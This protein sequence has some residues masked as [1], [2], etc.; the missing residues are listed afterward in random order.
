MS[1]AVVPQP[2]GAALLE[3]AVGYARAALASVRGTDP[4]AAT[5]CQQWDLRRLLEHMDDSL[6][7]FTEAATV[8]YVVLARPGPAGAPRGGLRTADPVGHLVVSLRERACALLAGWSA[9]PAGTVVQVA[10][11][12]VQADLLAAAGA[13]EIA[14]HG[15]DVAATCGADLPVPEAL[16][17]DLRTVLPVLVTPADRPTRFA[18]AHAVPPR[19]SAGDRLL[20]ELGRNP[21][22]ERQPS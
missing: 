8:G 3:R 1:G 21:R 12:P 13:L 14:V 20:A 19:A 9:R 10:G 15:W 4:T 2:D 11:R 6:A 7:A 16:A 5:P 18:A 17:T 22:W